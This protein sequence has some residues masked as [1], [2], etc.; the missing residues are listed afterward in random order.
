MPEL[1]DIFAELG[2]S[3]CLGDFVEH[4]FDTWHTI[5]DITES[6]LDALSVQ[7]SLATA[8]SSRG[9]SLTRAAY[10]QSWPFRRRDKLH[11]DVVDTQMGSG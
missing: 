11:P 1:Q 4:G 5:L 10:L 8:E 9:G 6:D 3:H 7:L 2:I